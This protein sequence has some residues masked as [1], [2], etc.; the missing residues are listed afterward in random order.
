MSVSQVGIKR[1]DV[2]REK[3]DA[4]NLTKKLTNIVGK[5]STPLLDSKYKE[6]ISFCALVEDGA[7]LR[8]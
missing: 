8:H 4:S 5:I 7:I 6:S 3:L 2:I 1:N